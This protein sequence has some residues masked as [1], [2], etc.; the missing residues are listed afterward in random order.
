MRF[1]VA[2]EPTDTTNNEVPAVLNPGGADHDP[3]PLTEAQAVRTRV[4]RF[5]RQNGQWAINQLFWDPARMD[6]APGQE[7]VEIW[8]FDNHSGGWF[9]PIHV[10]LVDFKVLDR[11]GQPPFPHEVGPKDVVYVGEGE[12]VRVIAK[13]GPRRGKYMMHC[14]NVIHEDHDMMT[15]FE[16]GQGGPDPVT[17]APPKPVSNPLPPLVK[18]TPPA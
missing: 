10:H 18:P 2:A 4:W 6:A 17:T 12:V 5:E 1:D 8:R 9:H 15:N 11:N 16:V 7:D 13:F 3:M 14:H